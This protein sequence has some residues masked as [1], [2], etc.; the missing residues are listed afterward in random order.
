MGWT[1]YGDPYLAGELE[2]LSHFQTVQFQSDIVLRAVRTWVIVYDN[3]VFTSLSCKIYSNETVGGDNS[4][5]KL[6]A[7]STD[8]RTKAEIHTLANG[9]K[10]IY[11]NFN[12]VP[13]KGADL[14]N[15]VLQGTGYAPAG[16]SHLAWM[17]GFPDPVYTAGYTPTLESLAVAPYQIYFIGG[18]F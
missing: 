9:I 8:V 5:R 11:F 14:Y 4:P 18:A 2:D 12:D 16:G 10:E 1:V 15:F 13:L 3:P 7:T 17:K 6:L